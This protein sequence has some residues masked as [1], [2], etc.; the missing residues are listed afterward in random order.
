MYAGWVTVAT[1]LNTTLLLKSFGVADPNIPIDEETSTCII[2]WVALIIYNVAT[3][4]E[5]NPLFGGI[6]IWAIFAI[7]HNIVNNK[8]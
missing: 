7:H 1:I 5:R 2:L 3:Y 6:Y 4:L 8:S